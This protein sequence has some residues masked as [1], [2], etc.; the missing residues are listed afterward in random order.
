MIRW[1]HARRCHDRPYLNWLVVWFGRDGR[2]DLQ[3]HPS[4]WDVVASC[5]RVSLSGNGSAT[6]CERTT[7]N[8]VW[9]F[10]ML[11]RIGEA[12]VVK[13]TH[14]PM[15]PDLQKGPLQ[16]GTAVFLPGEGVAE[17]EVLQLAHA[18]GRQGPDAPGDPIEA[19]RGLGVLREAD[20]AADDESVP[21]IELRST[22]DGYL[23]VRLCNLMKRDVLVL[24]GPAGASMRCGENVEIALLEQL[25][26]ETL[27][28][29]PAGEWFQSTKVPCAEFV[30]VPIALRN[31]SRGGVLGDSVSFTH[32]ASPGQVDA[33]FVDN[34]DLHLRWQWG[35]HPRVR[36]RVYALTRDERRREHVR[37]IVKRVTHADYA[38]KG[39]TLVRAAEVDT[40]LDPTG[41][42]VLEV[43]IELL[44]SDD[45]GGQGRALKTSTTRVAVPPRRIQL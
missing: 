25:G 16:L 38:L 36:I 34:N 20:R 40:L 28:A 3:L 45:I 7:K 4:R 17:T 13:L 24:T 8:G 37:P 12:C 35:A 23:E 15:T 27:L 11:L 43:T 19:V 32:V 39:F 10:Q 6:E 14:Q 5:S 18:R 22:E 1:W 31:G 21:V 26:F 44:R 33:E 9:Q 2:L 29:I 41:A 42:T 30:A